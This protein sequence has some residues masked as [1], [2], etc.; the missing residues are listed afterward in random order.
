M[1]QQPPGIQKKLVLTLNESNKYRLQT[2]SKIKNNL[3]HPFP[4]FVGA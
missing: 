4:D 3:I 1:K 2:T